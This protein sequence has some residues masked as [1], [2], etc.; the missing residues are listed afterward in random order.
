MKVLRTIVLPFT[1]G[2]PNSEILRSFKA[3]TLFWVGQE[4]CNVLD[5]TTGRYVGK[6]EVDNHPNFPKLLAAHQMLHRQFQMRGKFNLM[7]D[8]TLEFVGVVNDS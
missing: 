8:G 1:V 2:L 7:E 4:E 3:T 5:K 6:P